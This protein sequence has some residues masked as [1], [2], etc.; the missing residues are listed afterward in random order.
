MR[1]ARRRPEGRRHE[2]L[3]A[4]GGP[5]HAAA[6]AHRPPPSAWSDRWPADARHLARRAGA[7]GVDEVLVNTHHLADAGR[8]ARRRARRVRR[9]PAR[10]RAER[11]SA[12][13][14][15]CVPNRDFVAGRGRCSSR[16]TRT[17]SPT[18]TSRGCV[19]AHREGGAVATL[20]RFPGAPTRASAASSRSTPTVVSSASWRSP[21]ARA[22]TSP[23]PAC[24][25][26]TGVL[27]HIDGPD[28]CDIGSTCCP[29][30]SAGP[31]WSD[32]GD[33]YFRRHRHASGA[34][35]GAIAPGAKEPTA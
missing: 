28:P 26:S 19:D 30:W 29:G 10:P 2:G 11:C 27:D 24:T 18:S 32:I 8:G 20:V 13:P 31:G 6:A 7:A 9:G 4:R 35:R 34:G 14:A 5:R 12:A 25:P 23:T 17:T 15:P 16:S 21:P 22:A 33:A 1:V 3:P